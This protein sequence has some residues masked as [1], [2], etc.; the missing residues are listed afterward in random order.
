MTRKIR[1]LLLIDPQNDF[2]AP[3]AMGPALGVPGADADMHRIAAVLNHVRDPFF[4]ATHVSLDSHH[5]LDIAHPGW[6]TDITGNAPTPFTVISTEDLRTGRWLA[7]DPDQQ[8]W[9]LQY[10]ETLEARGKHALIV[11][12]EHCLIGS[13]GHL[14]H[15]ELAEALN[16]WARRNLRQVNY[17]F[18]G[19]NPRTE[20]YSALSA[21]V[22]VAEDE[23]T[24]FNKQLLAQL[25][26]AEEIWVAGEA[27]SHC[28]ASTVR[29][30]VHE[31]PDLAPRLWLVT[32]AMSPVTG[33]AKQGAEF[34]SEMHALGAHLTK[35]GDMESNR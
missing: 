28:V 17:V 31:R 20:H 15:E 26:P 14:I 29:D 19:M 16:N 5:P 9:S 35:I 30:L 12:P 33:F 6:W 3:A 32:D 27:L 7:R 4:D 13:W 1:H 34:L 11:W 22:P 8:R 18:K 21:E 24:L 2:C 25:D 10:V 23:H